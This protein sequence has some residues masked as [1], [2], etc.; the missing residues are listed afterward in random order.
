MQ[1]IWLEQALADFEE[2]AAYLEERN[3][4]AAHAFVQ[5]IN[6]ALRHLRTYPTAGRPGRVRNTR[7]LVVGQ[8]RYIIPYRVRQKRIELLAVIHDAREWPE[9]LEG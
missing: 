5:R 7:E 1:I 3:P 6:A 4:R 8:T 9:G 2:A